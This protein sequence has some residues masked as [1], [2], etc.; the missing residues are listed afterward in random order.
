MEN[1]KTVVK[2]GGLKTNNL[3][4]NQKEKSS[5]DKVVKPK[6]DKSQ[7]WS[8]NN[9]NLALMRGIRKK[10]RRRRAKME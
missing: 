10:S 3:K 4:Q 5:D 8:K 2:M 7:I 9:F 6:Q 1:Q